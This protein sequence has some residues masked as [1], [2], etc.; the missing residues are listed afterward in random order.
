M[1]KH[2]SASSTTK[3]YQ[4]RF[5]LYCFSNNPSHYYVVPV[6]VGDHQWWCITLTSL[7]MSVLHCGDISYLP[8]QLK[9]NVSHLLCRQKTNAEKAQLKVE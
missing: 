5:E 4:L 6:V 9:N 2:L 7:N 3:E 8:L 1:V